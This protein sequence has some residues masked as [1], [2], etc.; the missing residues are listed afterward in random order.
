[1]YAP[2]VLFFQGFLQGYP[3]HA[4]HPRGKGV[5]LASHASQ[6]LDTTTTTTTSQ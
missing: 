6:L 2:N 1:M 4:A 5:G 3:A